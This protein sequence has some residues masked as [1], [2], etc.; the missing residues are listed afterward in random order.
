[1]GSMLKEDLSFIFDEIEDPRLERS[2]KYPIGEIF[3]RLFLQHF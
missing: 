3:L 1:M 2:K